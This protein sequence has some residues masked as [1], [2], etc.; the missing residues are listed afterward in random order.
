[1]EKKVYKN[2]NGNMSTSDFISLIHNEKLDDYMR[3][4]RTTDDKCPPMELIKSNQQC[5]FCI[6]CFKHCTNQ[7]KEYKDYYKIKNKKYTK[8]ELDE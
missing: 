8:G 4:F 6:D 2:K 1:M 7:V 5:F 3:K